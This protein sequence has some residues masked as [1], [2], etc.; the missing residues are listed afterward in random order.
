MKCH[1]LNVELFYSVS[2]KFIRNTVSLRCSYS[3][4]YCGWQAVNYDGRGPVVYVYG[5]LRILFAY[6]A[7]SLMEVLCRFHLESKP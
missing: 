7:Q 3:P 5:L 6:R 2:Q 1:Y 4:L